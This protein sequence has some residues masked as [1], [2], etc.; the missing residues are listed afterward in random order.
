MFDFGPLWVYYSSVERPRNDFSGTLLFCVILALS[1]FTTQWLRAEGGILQMRNGYFWDPYTTEY[2]IPRGIAYQTW[3]PPVGAD[4]TFE[5]FDYDMT[6]FKKIYVNSVRAEFVWNEV[7]KSPGVYDW[8]KPDHMVAKAEELGFKL[9]ILVGFQYAPTWFPE[10]GKAVNSRGQRSVVLNYEHPS[11]RA[12]SSNYIYQATHRFRNSA[13]IGGWILGNEYAYFDLWDTNVLFLGFDT[14]SQASF[15]TFLANTYSNNISSLNSNWSTNY[16]SF[17]SVIMPTNYPAD[18]RSGA[19]FDLIQW[20]KKS[21]GDYV[22]AGAVAAKLAD[23]NHLRTY[24]MVGGIFSGDDSLNTCEDARAIVARCAAA[25]APLDFWSINNY[26]WASIGSE[27]RTADFGIAKYRQQSGLPVMISETGH[28]S[29]ESLFD[30]APARQ[31]KAIPSQMWEAL[32]SGA[33]GT[34]IFHWSDREM[35]GGP[36]LRERGFGFVQQNRLIKDPAYWNVLAMFRQ[37][38]NIKLDHL[39]GGS[40]DPPPDV[41]YFWSLN[42]DVVWPRANQENAML[43]GALRRAGYQPALLDD[44]QFHRGDYTNGRALILSAA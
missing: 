26:A 38:E 13:A 19:Y 14:F 32:V 8:N 29:T 43:W 22:A 39:I 44:G 20:R 15:R 16:S 17:G 31:A 36:F 27:M 6:E 42:G 34:H 35:F 9:F 28:S 7:E 33:I 40:V 21:I 5:Q 37:M 10:E 41:Q 2:F 24:S 11:A 3:N 30:G 23:P 25:G 1:L 4:Q 18:R 12:A